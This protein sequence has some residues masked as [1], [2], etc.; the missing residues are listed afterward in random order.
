MTNL[1]T[2]IDTLGELQVRIAA[3][4]AEA[5]ALKAV[6]IEV[7]PGSYEGDKFKVVVTKP[8]TRDQ[9]DMTAVKA[10][11]SPQFKAAH[12]TVVNVAPSV[13]VSARMEAVA[14]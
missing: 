8:S 2:T 7:G 6:L 11:L 1:T 4:E 9:L 5:K 10:F 14:A 3:L 13:R 12:T